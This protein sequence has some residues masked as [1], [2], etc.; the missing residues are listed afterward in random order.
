MFFFKRKFGWEKHFVGFIC[1]CSCKWASPLFVG[2]WYTLKHVSSIHLTPC[3]FIFVCFSLSLSLSSLFITREV[4]ALLGI[5]MCLLVGSREW[6]NMVKSP[7][8]Q[9]NCQVIPH[10]MF[11]SI[12]N[13]NMKIACTMKWVSTIAWKWVELLNF[14]LLILWVLNLNLLRISWMLNVCGK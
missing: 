13:G 5:I 6:Q 12:S 4:M 3:I 2:V 1:F 10:F 9:L 14:A 7:L 11:Q 8:W